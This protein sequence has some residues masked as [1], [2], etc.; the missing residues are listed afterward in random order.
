[1]RFDKP[2]SQDWID[3]P[4]EYVIPEIQPFIDK[5][6]SLIRYDESLG[7]SLS[8]QLKNHTDK[9]KIMSVIPADIRLELM[10]DPRFMGRVKQQI[11]KMEENPICVYCAGRG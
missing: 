3:N 5:I 8:E 9:E 11:L 6:K 2:K 7:T 4:I 10:Y 1:M